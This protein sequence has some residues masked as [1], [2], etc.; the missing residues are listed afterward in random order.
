M[1]FT[2]SVDL[3]LSTGNTQQVSGTLS[4]A[5]TCIRSTEQQKLYSVS[6]NED[7]TII[8]LRSELLIL[9]HIYIDKK[10]KSHIFTYHGN[11]V[12]AIHVYG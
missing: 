2:G 7:A 10:M 12:Q 5:L 9:E 11:R 1:I 8:N 4:T 3:I 6:P